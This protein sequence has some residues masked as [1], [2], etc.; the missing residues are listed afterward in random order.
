MKA[1]EHLEL[2]QLEE[3]YWWF[4]GRREL[5]AQMVGQYHRGPAPVILDAGCGT[6]GTMA[7]VAA[8]GRV[9]GC[10]T[11]T[12]ALGFCRKRGFKELL[13]GDVS[14]LPFASG[15]LDVVL[16]CDVLEHTLDDRAA[17][18]ELVRVLR[19]GGTLVLTVP[20]HRFLWSEHDEA[21]EHRRRY[22]ARQLRRMLQDSGM[23]VAKLSP[24]VVGVFL[25][26]LL[27][28]LL[29][30]LRPKAP[31]APRT[32]LR[33]LPRFTND[34][35]VQGLRLENWLLRRMNL[36]VGTSLV[37]VAHKPGGQ[38]SQP[39]GGHASDAGG[40]VSGGGSR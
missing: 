23:L 20:A 8:L 5:V 27:F 37:A 14:A 9:V 30:R 38:S 39:E 17:L 40:S 11:S 35:L 4:I 12:Y 15:S 18:A 1:R 16:N 33:V 6:G 28:R 3:T 24:V 13:A 31:D 21:L 2:Y 19:P 32:D 7:Q 10:D 26:I 25:P 29:Q 34:L 22:S 36:P